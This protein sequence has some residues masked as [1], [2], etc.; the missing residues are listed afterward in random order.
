MHMSG[1]LAT[2]RI[3]I[4]PKALAGIEE[5]A[6]ARLTRFEAAGHARAISG[7]DER[8][9]RNVLGVTGEQAVLLWLRDVLGDAIEIRDAADAP[10]GPSDLEVTTA[11]GTLGVEVKTT[12]Y[13]RWLRFGRV[14]AEEQVWGTDAEIYVWCAG[15]DVSGPREIHIV[16]WSTTADVRRDYAKQRFTRA[17]DGSMRPP[18]VVAPKSRNEWGPDYGLDDSDFDDYE[19][20]QS[21]G[22]GEGDEAGSIDDSD[23]SEPVVRHQAAL[24][25]LLTSPEWREGNEPRPGFGPS[26][27]IVRANAPVRPLAALADWVSQ[28]VPD[29]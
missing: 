22:L 10:D 14:I 8:L 15:P 3:D 20:N 29:A 9:R 11:A 5:R 6:R 7:D 1:G 21:A 13:D 26:R 17:R 12:T 19:W 23:M 2:L 24:S 16:G 18:P 25:T 4:S 27:S 28:W